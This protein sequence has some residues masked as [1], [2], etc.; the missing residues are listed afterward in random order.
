MLEAVDLE[1]VRGARRLFLGLGCR[2]GRG[3]IL[4]VR[5]A[6]GAG[7]TSLL[8]ILCGLSLPAAGEVLWGGA[9]LADCRAEFHRAL[10]YLGHRDALPGDLSALQNLRAACA[11]AGRAALVS[12]CAEA[13]ARMGLGDCL[14]LPCR[15]LSAGQRRRAAI[16]GLWLRRGG[17]W[18]L[19]EPAAALDAAAVADLQAMLRAQTADGGSV[20]FTSHRELAAD[21]RQLDLADFA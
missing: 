2:L 12:E 8:R 11:L 18:I 7:K 15:A 6:N 10:V 4:H 20:I 16:A 14:R 3:D 5:G 19:D 17:V 9:P 1:C 13:L 21:A